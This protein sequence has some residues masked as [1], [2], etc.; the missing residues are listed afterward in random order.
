MHSTGE[1]TQLLD[2]TDSFQITLPESDHFDDSLADDLCELPSGQPAPHCDENKVN[3]D[4][5]LCGD[6]IDIAGMDDT[7]LEENKQSHQESS[8]PEEAA[9]ETQDTSRYGLN[10]CSGLCTKEVDVANIILH[11]YPTVFP[12]QVCMFYSPFT[13]LCHGVIVHMHSVANLDD[14]LIDDDDTQLPPEV[15]SMIHSDSNVTLDDEKKITVQEKTKEP[16]FV[17]PQSVIE[18]KS[19]DGKSDRN[20]GQLSEESSMDKHSNSVVTV[21]IGDSVTSDHSTLSSDDVPNQIST[22]KVRPSF[23]K[24]KKQFVA[25]TSTTL[26]QKTKSPKLTEEC[27]LP[28]DTNVEESP[29]CSSPVMQDSINK[30]NAP[31]KRTPETSFSAPKKTEALKVKQTDKP[32]VREGATKNTAKKA[33]GAGGDSNKKEQKKQNNVSVKQAREQ[34]RLEKEKAKLEKER[35]RKEKCLEQERKKAEREQNKMD[36]ELKKLE[37]AQKNATKNK[38]A[39]VKPQ[40]DTVTDTSTPSGGDG[41]GTSGNLSAITETV[42]QENVDTISPQPAERCSSGI[43]SECITSTSNVAPSDETDN[44]TAGKEDDPELKSGETD[45]DS[46]TDDKTA[47]VETEPLSS[48][49]VDVHSTPSNTDGIPTQKQAPNTTAAH[50]SRKTMNQAKKRLLPDNDKQDIGAKKF[51][52]NPKN[53]KPIKKGGGRKSKHSVTASPVTP[54][55]KGKSTKAVKRKAESPQ[56]SEPE[57]KRSKPANY[58]G[59]VWVQCDNVDCQKWRNLKS[60]SDPSVVPDNWTCSM[61]DELDYNSCSAPEEVLSDLG[62]SQE[63]I[64]SPFIPGSLVWAKMDGY[65]WY[66]L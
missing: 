50:V 30:E 56:A 7:Q 38:K 55:T 25:P 8:L 66:V 51:K 13:S 2:N 43:E 49:D 4:D 45:T 18:P 26:P 3:L 54:S 34:K 19:V 9:T 60:I 33:T 23:G 48:V 20:P 16:P 65:P 22:V 46:K 53:A 24:K 39:K 63:F 17:S 58:S 57:P 36:K 37:K 44:T 5:S 32:Q 40:T 47:E 41:D 21:T 31:S 28:V 15:A 6:D 10:K 42:N 62:D 52:P 64:E 1:E 29:T 27:H 61:N 11:S 12:Y 59:P 35:L 14:S